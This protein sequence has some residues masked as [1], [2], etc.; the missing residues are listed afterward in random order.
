MS[1]DSSSDEAVLH[2][3]ASSSAAPVVP[4]ARSS[5]IVTD[6]PA[7][8]NAE[9]PD[10]NCALCRVQM[11]RLGCPNCTYLQCGKCILKYSNKEELG[12]FNCKNCEHKYK[13]T[14]I[15]SEFPVRWSTTYLKKF[16]EEGYAKSKIEIEGND[17]L[18]N[19]QIVIEKVMKKITLLEQECKSASEYPYEEYITHELIS[20]MAE[21][22]AFID[23]FIEAAGVS[24]DSVNEQIRKM[25]RFATCFEILRTLLAKTVTIKEYS[26]YCRDCAPMMGIDAGRR[27]RTVTTASA[28][29]NDPINKKYSAFI[30]KCNGTCNASMCGLCYQNLGRTSAVYVYHGCDISRAVHYTNFT[31]S[32]IKTEIE[33]IANDLAKIMPKREKMLTYHE[34]TLEVNI[35]NGKYIKYKDYEEDAIPIL[36][37]ALKNMIIAELITTLL[38]EILSDVPNIRT[39]PALYANSIVEMR[40][41]IGSSNIFKVKAETDNIVSQYISDIRRGSVGRMIDFAFYMLTL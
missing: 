34:Q 29:P 36:K 30:V 21:S 17:T 11:E 6:I 37:F 2:P 3:G 33:T 18:V 28:E 24:I 38:A 22:D 23:A 7:I 32:N 26:I 27:L 1:D 5:R 31:A 20:K 4:V 25:S 12:V 9:K 16:A 41:K 39:T 15:L 35:T 19:R 13:I 14:D 40:K 10:V 8:V